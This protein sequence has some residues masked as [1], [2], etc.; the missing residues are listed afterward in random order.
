MKSFFKGVRRHIAKLDAD[1]LREQYRL[2]MDEFA[3][4]EAIFHSLKEGVV[5]LDQAG[6]VTSSNPAAKELLGMEPGD[7]VPRLAPPLGKTSRREI[8]LTYPEARVVEMQ[9]VPM[10]AETLEIGRAH[11]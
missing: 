2:V 5:V 4:F 6:G 7:M 9:T 1:K 10:G 3:Y 11:G 8:E